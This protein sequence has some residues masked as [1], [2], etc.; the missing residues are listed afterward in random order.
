MSPATQE[1]QTGSAQVLA[2]AHPLWGHLIALRA[3]PLAFLLRAAETPGPLVPLRLAYRTAWL[4]KR[5]EVLKHVFYN[6]ASNYSKANLHYRL[7]RRLLGDGLLTSTDPLQRERRCAVVHDLLRI[8]PARIAA[9]AD[10]AVA[11]ELSALRMGGRAAPIRIGDLAARLSLA[12][13]GETVLRSDLSHH[14]AA[15]DAAVHQLNRRFGEWSPWSF[16][17]W[18]PTAENRRCWQSIKVVRRAAQN[19][20]EQTHGAPSLRDGLER[21]ACASPDYPAGA[22]K[23]LVD[24]IVTLI[25]AGYETTSL[26]ITWALVLLAQHTEWQETIAAELAA[27][28]APPASFESRALTLVLHETLRLYPPVWMMSRIAGNA[29]TLVGRQIR[30]GALVLVSP[31]VIHRQPDLWESP[32][33]FR[34]GRFE[35]GLPSGARALAYCPFGAGDRS[36]IGTHIALA[37]ARAVVGSLVRGIRFARSE[38]TH[39]APAALATLYPGGEVRL[40]V[41]RRG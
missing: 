26:A 16:L 14:A 21:A 29:D 12:V 23:Y 34:P 13:V 28:P 20:L 27:H 37:V 15:V 5:P 36:C 18:I 30:R 10:A 39:V 9:V 32:D 6:N 4:V 35:H 38:A 41:E 31:Y 8:E 7:M 17:P 2:D 22:E 25:V 24:E 40:L 3:H 11:R 1:S 19:L 33:E